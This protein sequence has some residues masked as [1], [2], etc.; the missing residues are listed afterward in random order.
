MLVSTVPNLCLSTLF[1]HTPSF[2][3][4]EINEKEMIQWHMS[5]PNSHEHKF[6]LSQA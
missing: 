3:K 5:T 2:C 6:P 4:P 1:Q